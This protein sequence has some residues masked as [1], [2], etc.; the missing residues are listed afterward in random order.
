MLVLSYRTKRWPLLSNTLLDMGH[1]AGHAG[2]EQA[3]TAACPADGAYKT[4]RKL[5]L[6]VIMRPYLDNLPQ[7]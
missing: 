2:K 5:Q 7:S 6:R 4:H 1:V 3:V